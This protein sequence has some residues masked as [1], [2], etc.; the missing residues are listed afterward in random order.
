MPVTTAGM[1]SSKALKVNEHEKQVFPVGKRNVPVVE[2]IQ[3][4][5][6]PVFIFKFQ[7]SSGFPGEP[8]IQQQSFPFCFSNYLW[9]KWLQ[10]SECEAFSPERHFS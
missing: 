8:P 4:K 5:L 1:H 10:Y 7:T 3:K 6:L 9:V 2:N